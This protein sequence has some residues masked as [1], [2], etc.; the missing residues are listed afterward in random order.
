MFLAPPP[1]L[2]VSLDSVVNGICAVFCAA[3]CVFLNKIGHN[4]SDDFIKDSILIICH[5]GHFSFSK[6]FLHIA[7]Y[8]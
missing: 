4:L 1:L 2:R 8:T 6:L 5:C 7:R 3:N